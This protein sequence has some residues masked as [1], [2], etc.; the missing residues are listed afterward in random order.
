MKRS[1]SF[2]LVLLV[3]LAV[4][5]FA[6]AQAKQSRN[7]AAVAATFTATATERT[8]TRECTGADGTYKL[9]R[10]VYEGTAAGDPLLAGKIV[11][12]MESVVNATSGL[13]WSKGHVSFRDADGKLKAKASLAAVVSG[14]SALDGFMNGR[15]KE[16]GH[17]LANFS[18]AFSADGSS[19]TGSLGSGAAV[20]SAILTK[21][22]C[23]KAGRKGDDE[24][25]KDDD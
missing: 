18:A 12:R 23:E 16:G 1:F 22:A 19:L 17:L 6:V 13:G 9:T 3:A 14:S 20:N 4:T 8:K 5:G 11:I 10:A 2:A 25:K 21:G 24:K 15:V 7:T